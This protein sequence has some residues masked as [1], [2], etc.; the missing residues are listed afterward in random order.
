MD[1][2][3][4][5]EALVSAARHSEHSERAAGGLSVPEI[6]E[7]RWIVESDRVRLSWR[8]ERECYGAL[9]LRGVA[10]GLESTCLTPR[11]ELALAWVDQHVPGALAG[12][13]WRVRPLRPP[14]GR[15]SVPT[16]RVAR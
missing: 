12:A 10:D 14:V 15:A 16:I 9:R 7:A 5:V 2:M 1:H 6:R 3:D 4:L 13:E 8:P 11:L